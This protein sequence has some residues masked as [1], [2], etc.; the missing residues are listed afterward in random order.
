MEYSD[1]CG[2]NKFV[3]RDVDMLLAEE[4]R[5]NAAFGK[6]IMDKFDA[7][8]DMIFPA[9]HVNVSV[10]EDGSEADVIA[11]FRTTSNLNHRLFVENKIDAILMPEQLERYLRRA[12]G[13]QKRQLVSAFSILFFTPSAY[14]KTKLPNGVKQ[15]SFE[16]AAQALASQGDLRSQYRASLLMRA[17]PIRTLTARDAH[18]AVTDPFIKDWWDQVYAMLDREFPGF[19]IHKTRYPRSVYFAPET[20]GQGRY[21]RLD[22]KGHKG[23]VDLAFKNISVAALSKQVSNMDGLP[24]QI[25]ANGKSSAIQMT[26]LAPFVISDGFDVIQT[27]VYAAYEAAHTLLTF[28]QRNR[29]QFDTLALQIETRSEP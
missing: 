1:I 13:D 21:L 8:A 12:E 26:G 7:A 15:I 25:V 10:V 11:T 2:I 6:W 28:W 17:L 22:F 3:E 19:F 27:R 23:E 16:E 4:L 9:A 5:V 29:V 18:V 20:P 24:G 14:L